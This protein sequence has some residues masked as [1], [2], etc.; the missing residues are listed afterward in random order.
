MLPGNAGIGH[1]DEEASSKQLACKAFR[2]YGRSR[3]KSI[4]SVSKSFKLMSTD[5]AFRVLFLSCN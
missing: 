1:F 2:R 4:K 5:V 3:R